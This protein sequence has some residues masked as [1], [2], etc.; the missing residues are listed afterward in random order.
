MA[1]RHYM[2]GALV[3]LG[4]S[5]QE[6]AGRLVV[7]ANTAQTHRGHII[8]KLGLEATIDLIRYAIRHGLIEA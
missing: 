8:R 6:I 4:L 2:T 1:A 3:M 5:N 7:S